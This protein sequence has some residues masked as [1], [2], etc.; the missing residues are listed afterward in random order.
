[1]SSPAELVELQ[2]EYW[3][4][5][6]GKKDKSS[7]KTSFRSL[8]VSRLPTLGDSNPAGSALSMVVVTKDK[9]KKSKLFLEL[10]TCH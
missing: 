4:E 7:I 9:N 6:G 8:T 3:P 10:S 1:M 2:V 5:S